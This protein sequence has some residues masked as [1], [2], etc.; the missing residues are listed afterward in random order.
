M[1]TAKSHWDAM[2]THYT[3]NEIQY[4]SWLT[5]F[6]HIIDGCTAPIID[7]GCGSGNDT[8][9]LIERGKRVIP[10]DYAPNAIANIRRNFPELT[11]AKCFDMTEG[12]PFP[13]GCTELVIADLSLHYFSEAVTLGVLS[14]LKRILT[15]DGHLLLRVNSVK[16]VYHGAG[17]G[18]EVERHFY[19]T[20]DGRY[21]R[22][23]DEEDIRRIFGA[24]HILYC[25]ESQM[26]RYDLPKQLWTVLCKGK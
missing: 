16:D 9:Y 21:K 24:W 23:F 6:P 18:E 2:H 19:R 1:P 15:P 26:H 8:K 20:P 7:L 3:R 12:L 4:D 5:A 13:D 14:E 25:E 17:E 10:C 11:D 22:F